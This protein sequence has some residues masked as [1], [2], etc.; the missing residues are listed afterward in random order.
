[1]KDPRAAAARALAPV[2]RQQASLSGTLAQGRAVEGRDRALFQE[3]CFGAARWAPR[4]LPMLDSLLAKPLKAEDAD[5]RALLLIGAY[6]LEYTRVPPHAALSATVEASRLLGKGWA[7][8]LVNAILRRFQRE[9]DSLEAGLSPWQRAGYPEWLYRRM[10]EAWPG[11]AEAALAAGNGHPPLWLRVNPRQ[12][13]RDDYLGRLAAAGIAAAAGPAPHSI[14]LEQPLDVSEL[15]GWSEGCASVQD[16][17][18]Q[19]SAE[20]LEL[21]DGQRALDACCAPGGK[22]CHLLELAP[23][24]ELLGVEL[25]QPRLAR[26]RD[27]LQRLGLQAGLICAD[28][29]DPASWWDGR[30]FDRILIDAPC[31]ATGV[32]RRH[33][34]IK[35]LRRQADIAPLAELQGR[36]LRALWATLAPG[37]TLVYATC[38]LLPEENE[39]VIQAFLAGEPGASADTPALPGA[40][41]TGAGQQFLP[42]EGGGDG[43]YYCRLRKAA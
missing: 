32:I 2:L 9:R 21:A 17:S 28:A 1:M 16:L 5:I 6:Q 43:F 33:P 26:V 42:A 31:S 3:L 7:S 29:T 25:E 10:L 24:A 14:R 18:A 20:L 19:W 8:K 27:N 37:G 35:L 4:L 34:D 23:G 38:S 12:S 36:M 39:Q 13:S 11:Q 22:L 41:G 15:P 40:A 30:A